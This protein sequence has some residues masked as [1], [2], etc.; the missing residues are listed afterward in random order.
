MYV[1]ITSSR[2]GGEAL[3]A[4]R[5]FA[6]AG[7]TPL[8]W[9]P[10]GIAPQGWLSDPSPDGETLIR[11]AVARAAGGE[12]PSGLMLLPLERGWT[13]ADGLAVLETA[14]RNPGAMVAARRAGGLP[15]LE[16]VAAW[17]YRFTQGRAVH[18]LYAGLAV[19]PAQLVGAL[20]RP[21]RKPLYTRALLSVRSLNLPLAEVELR[22]QEPPAVR[23]AAAVVWNML[24]FLAVFLR[25]TCSSLLSAGVDYGLF[26]LLLTPLHYAEAAH[27]VARAV[28]STVN[29]TLNRMLVFS[30]RQSRVP[31]AQALVR[32]FALAVVVAAVGTGLIRLF[33]TVLGLPAMPVK[34]AVDIL[35][36]VISFLVQRELV[37]HRRRPRRVPRTAKSTEPEVR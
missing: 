26:A 12:S 24:C 28:S 25:F 19:W 37:F 20:N 14:A 30:D 27:A 35:L 1:L 2:T 3:E 11:S 22:P 15:A 8:I 17:I 10:D 23:P 6:A 33:S 9:S 5:A 29:F 32:Y 13:A 7:H 31:L 36:Y 21:G 34:L 16:R 4:A 18:D